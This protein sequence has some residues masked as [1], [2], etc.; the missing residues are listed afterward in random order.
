[1]LQSRHYRHQVTV[2]T[3][4]AMGGKLSKRNMP[5]TT[6]T[7]TALR[8]HHVEHE[9]EKLPPPEPIVLMVTPHSFPSDDLMQE[10][11]ENMSAHYR[12]DFINTSNNGKHCLLVLLPNHEQVHA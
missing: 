3:I 1:M 10:F 5:S 4:D 8:V 6:T 12:V 7:Y 9:L 2:T 11:V